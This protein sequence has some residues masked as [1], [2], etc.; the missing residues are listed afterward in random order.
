[1]IV[2]YQITYGERINQTLE[3]LRRVSPYV[4]R[5]IIV[6]D[7]VTEDQVNEMK[8]YGAEVYVTPWK[9]DFA[10]YKNECLRRCNTG[11]WLVIS[12]SDEFFCDEFCRD[13]KKIISDAERDGYTMLLINSHDHSHQED[14]TVSIGISSYYKR[15]IIRKT[16][17]CRYIGTGV[18]KNL[19]EYLH[20]DG[21]EKALDN[22]YY[23]E[24][25]KE[26][27]QVW[28]RAARDVYMGGGGFSVG[29]NNPKWYPLREICKN[30]GIKDWVEMRDYMRKG[31]IDQ[32][33]KDWMIEN[34][35]DGF[36][37]QHEMMEMFRWYFEYLHPEEN[38][39]NWKPLPK[40][41]ERAIVTEFIEK[42]YLRV[43]G[44]HAD[45]SGR[46]HWV[47]QIMSGKIQ[48]HQIDGIFKNSLEYK[49]RFK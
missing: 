3:C 26:W 34:R 13:L 44:R 39:G 42:E 40:D 8:E 27:H 20:V 16:P 41:D 29:R 23:Y 48:K 2:Y 28:E 32:R 9:D 18:A 47:N 46:D 17:I 31:N 22:K 43:L 45:P 38:T 33:I 25:H 35:R 12:D 6:C 7:D 11:D 4:D 15:V 5:I 36:D 10:W 21:K 49:R 30:V 19:H 1:M 24:H 14:G 37:Y